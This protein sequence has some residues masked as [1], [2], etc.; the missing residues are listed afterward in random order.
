MKYY[1]ASI[2]SKVYFVVLTALL[3]GGFP[4]FMAQEAFA[5]RTF[6]SAVTGVTAGD[7]VA[8]TNIVLTFSGTIYTTTAGGPANKAAQFAVAGSTVNTANIVTSVNGAGCA[9]AG[10]TSTVTLVLA[11]AIATDAVPQVTFTNDATVL[12]C[13][14]DA[15]V[16]GVARTPTDGLSPQFSSAS[17]SGTTIDVVFTET[18]DDAGTVAITDF[19]LTGNTLTGT[20][21]VSGSTVSLTV[22]TEIIEG[23]VL[24]IA[25]GE[26]NGD[27]EDANNNFVRTFTAQS[28]T[29]GAATP[30]SNGSG[31]GDC[32][33]PTL[34]VNSES[35]RIVEGGFSYNGKPTDAERF[36]T[37]YPLITATVGKQNT[38][39]FKIYED[40]GPENI[41][42]FSFAFGLDKGQS[43]GESKAMIELDIDHEGTETVT[44]TD[45]ENAL[46]NIKVSTNIENCNVSDS[47]TQCL[48]VTIDHKFRAP[49]DFNI[50]GTDVWDMQRNS[51]QNYF[52]HGIEV[53]GESL[54][55][56]NEY[57]GINAGHIYHLTE[58]SKNT[59][60]D[61]FGNS[62]SF[63]YGK[64]IKDFVQNERLQDTS[65]VFTRNHSDFTE[66]KELQAQN[67]IPQLLEY[68]P[69][70]LDSYTDFKDSFGY[71]ISYKLNALDN[72]EIIQKM[73]LEN[74]RAQKIMNYLL[75]PVKYR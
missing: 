37:P 38:A 44:V 35:K 27:L 71:E 14:D 41:K 10:A 58:T 5:V 60:L 7:S 49:L 73:L 23:D 75:D 19:T 69:S 59:A 39:V 11:A 30:S 46:D 24:T 56:A 45:P 68:C 15:A 43:I 74:E 70:C 3:V 42:H 31:C 55:P 52:N 8:D 9:A 63:Q 51:W 67:A 66:Y 65:S 54:N 32:E 18:I 2:R 26:T 17:A 50:V 29:N 16:V 28:V 33:A 20:P 21:S 1:M 25:Y 48:I 12:S 62:W 57:D 40:K 34:G 6:D 13:D 4:N 47:D 22:T 72:P 64:W 36:F 53:T 61:E